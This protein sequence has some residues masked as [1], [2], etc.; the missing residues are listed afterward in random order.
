[1]ND[2]DFIW[3]RALDYDQKLTA[4]GDRALRDVLTFDGTASNGGL[5]NAVESFSEDPEFPLERVIEGFQYFAMERTAILVSSC[6]AR[7]RSAVDRELESIE[8]EFDPQYPVAGEDLSVAL[9]AQ[10]STAPQAFQARQ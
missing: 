9:E 4:P 6:A 5:L 2:A 3:H 8:I 10:L 1:M 7:R